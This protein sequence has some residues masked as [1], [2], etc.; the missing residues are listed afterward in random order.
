M[1]GYESEFTKF[2]RELK[3]QNPQMEEGQQ[4][5]YALLWDK[6]IDREAQRGFKAAKVPQQGYPY[7]NHVGPTPDAGETNKGG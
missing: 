3:Q 6:R 2:I 4:Q 5:G 7:Q 1:A